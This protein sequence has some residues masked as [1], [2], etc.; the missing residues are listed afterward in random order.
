ML[1][2][3]KSNLSKIHSAWCEVHIYSQTKRIKQSDNK[4]IYILAVHKIV[5]ITPHDY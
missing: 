3:L 5:A 4:I 1:F 2:L